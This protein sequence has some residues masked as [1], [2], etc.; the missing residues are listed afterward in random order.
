MGRDR[1]ALERGM[2]VL[3]EQAQ[4]GPDVEYDLRSE[5]QALRERLVEAPL[6]GLIEADLR[7]EARGRRHDDKGGD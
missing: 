7:H 1:E 4:I 3:R 5:G 2:I 6:P